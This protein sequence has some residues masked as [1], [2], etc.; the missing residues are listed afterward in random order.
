MRSK[1]QDINNFST[2]KC[3]DSEKSNGNHDENK[4]ITKQKETQTLLKITFMDPM[5]R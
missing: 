2:I 3:Y 4:I 5:V 1:T